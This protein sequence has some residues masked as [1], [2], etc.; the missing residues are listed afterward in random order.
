MP[1]VSFNEPQHTSEHG[2]TTLNLLSNTKHNRKHLFFNVVCRQ[3]STLVYH[4]QLRRQ[5]AAQEVRLKG[6]HS[7]GGWWT[8]GKCQHLKKRHKH[9]DK[10]KQGM[11]L[12]QEQLWQTQNIWLLWELKRWLQPQ[13][14]CKQINIWCVCLWV[15]FDICFL[16]SNALVL[17]LLDYFST[18]KLY[19]V[20][21]IQSHEHFE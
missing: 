15:A 18:L 6:K 19:F 16:Y 1:R 12:T 4:L 14:L 20:S 21:M 10:G 13:A 2:L 5:P 11:R 8:G 9:T 7:E 3:Y 17:N